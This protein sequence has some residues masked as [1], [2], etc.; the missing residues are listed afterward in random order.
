[1]K[2]ILS[3]I[4]L[5][6]ASSILFAQMPVYPP[7]HIAPLDNANN[8]IPQILLNWTPVSGA[9]KYV[10]QLDTNQAFSNPTVFSSIYSALVTPDLLFNANYYWR[11]A[12]IG[13]A[14][15]TSAWSTEW[16]FNVIDTLTQTAP[17]SEA[18]VITPG[19]PPDTSVVSYAFSPDVFLK[20]NAV[21]SVKK[22]QVHI[23]TDSSFSAI[24]FDS[25]VDTNNTNAYHLNYGDTVY[26]RVRMI[27][28]IDT[29]SWSAIWVIYIRN[30]IELQTPADSSENIHLLANLK[31]S[32]I[33]GSDF[34]EYEIVEDAGMGS[35]SIMHV[36]YSKL[37]L[38]A[39]P[40]DTIVETLSDTLK[41]GMTYAWRA[42]AVHAVGTSSWSVIHIF[43]TID[44]VNLVSP[45]DGATQIARSPLLSWDTIAGASSYDLMYDTLP[46]FS[47]P[48]ATVKNTAGNSLAVFPAL[49]KDQMVYWKVRARTSVD[50]SSWSEAFS[51][52][53]VDG[54]GVEEMIVKDLNVYPNPTKGFAE[55]SFFANESQKAVVSISNIIG[56]EVYTSVNS[57][58]TGN[59]V[60]KIDLS[61]YE[62]GIY[63][64]KL[65]TKNNSLSKK[66]ILNK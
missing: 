24:L 63:I 20:W 41:F 1:M 27:N 15:D 58:N 32:G 49:P 48:M 60:I 36:N 55:I 28:T 52:T 54:V 62:N 25:I 12:A 44:T 33:T 56:Q 5:F 46:S 22:Y 7:T 42:R 66:L 18:V 65:K 2:K 53:T 8:R 40:A 51:F 23:A 31:F 64:V 11:V 4:V 59:N 16:M 34:F 30:Y 50:V 37:K 61:K 39:N 19:T 35:S 47:S 17:I 3:I 45:A 43:T 57:V 38:I 21:D 29:S 26:W 10:V 9:T 6:L 13:N 14:N